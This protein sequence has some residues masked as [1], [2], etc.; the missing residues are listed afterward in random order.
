MTKPEK[1]NTTK[2]KKVE[3]NDYTDKKF[4]KKFIFTKNVVEQLWADLENVDESISEHDVIWTLDYLRYYTGFDDRAEKY[5]ISDRSLMAHVW[6]VIDAAK[7][8]NFNSQ[9]A[10]RVNQQVKDLTSE[11]LELFEKPILT[12]AVDTSF[13]PLNTKDN[14][15]NNPKYSGKGLKYEFGCSLYDGE[16]LWING[17]FKGPA[18]DISIFRKSL[19]KVSMKPGERF[20]G[21]KAYRG[22]KN[23]IL[24]PHTQRNMNPT[25]K[26]ENQF[27]KR[28]HTIIENVFNIFKRFKCFKN[29]W[30]SS[31][32]RH[33]NALTLIAYTY[34]LSVKIERFRKSKEE[35]KNNGSSYCKSS[36]NYKD[37]YEYEY[38]NIN[39]EE[40]QESDSDPALE[41]H[42]LEN[43]RETFNKSNV[44]GAD[45]NEEKNVI[46][47]DELVYMTEN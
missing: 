40:E 20:I 14:S 5:G 47:I 1:K 43:F 24:T 4:K 33:L 7:K 11:G 45:E 46:D 36:V 26:L 30:N 21:D 13:F 32:Q 2:K 37:E 31:I 42:I 44:D 15:F 35:E 6:K 25:E 38:E 18:L 16:V 17:P 22:E 39:S 41:E 9:L 23:R 12:L 19:G 10:D 3:I 34:N 28:K 29:K 8:L 27:I